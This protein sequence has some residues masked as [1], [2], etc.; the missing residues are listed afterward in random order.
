M[1]KQIGMS[2]ASI[3]IVL[4]LACSGWADDAPDEQTLQAWLALEEEFSMKEI[5]PITFIGGEAGY[6]VH[7][8]FPKRG[9][10]CEEATILVRPQ[11]QQAKEIP[12]VSQTFTVLDLD[13]DGI[14]EIAA[15]ATHMG[16]G[17]LEGRWQ[18]YALDGWTP[19]LLY[20][21]G[22]LVIS[23][24][25]AGCGLPDHAYWNRPCE[26]R[27]ITL[28]YDDLNQDQVDDLLVTIEEETFWFKPGTAEDIVFAPEAEQTQAIDPASRSLEVVRHELLYLERQFVARDAPCPP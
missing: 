3:S 17:W 19:V 21:Y 8:K 11:H 5:Q 7:G 23:N 13:G 1:M 14:S 28:A 2:L 4:F 20:D 22:P 10:C 24:Q 18:I 9:R 6:L 25:Q 27:T 16:Q 26:R 12:V 15:H